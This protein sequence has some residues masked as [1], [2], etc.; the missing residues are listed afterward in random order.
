MHSEYEAVIGL[1]IHTQ[2]NTKSKLF[3]SAASRFGDEPNTNI[4]EVC[5]AQPGS[6]PVINVEAIKKAILFG[7]AI[8][9]DISKLTTFD[10]KS[11]FYPDLPRGFQITQFY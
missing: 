4:S 5:T 7:L 9:A 1:E 10:R 3:S 11:Y 8:D 6:L 2:L